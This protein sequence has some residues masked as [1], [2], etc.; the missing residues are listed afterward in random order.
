MKCLSDLLHEADAHLS[1]EMVNDKEH[2]IDHLSP[3]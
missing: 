2:S 3:A 1:R